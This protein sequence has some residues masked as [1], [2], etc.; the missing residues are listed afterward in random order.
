MNEIVAKQAVP[1]AAPYQ[2]KIGKVIT[3]MTQPVQPD[4]QPENTGMDGEDFEIAEAFLKD[5]GL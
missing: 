2:R 5:M 1:M 3:A 4:P